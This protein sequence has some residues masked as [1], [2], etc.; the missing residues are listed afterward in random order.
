MAGR[1]VPAGV[2]HARGDAHKYLRVKGA[3]AG[4]VT[5]TGVE[6]GDPLYAVIGLGKMSGTYFINTVADFTAEF[7]TLAGKINNTGGTATTN[8]L[9]LVAWEDLNG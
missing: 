1:S 4:D 6:A 3:A 7:T 2:H 8:W 5:V 9:L